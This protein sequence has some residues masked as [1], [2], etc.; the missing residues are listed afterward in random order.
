MVKNCKDIKFNVDLRHRKAIIYG[1]NLIGTTHGDGAKTHDLPLLLAHEFKAE[2]AKTKFRYIYTN[3]IHHK[4][5]KDY[6]GVTIESSRSLSAADRWHADNGYQHA[7]RALEVY[8]HCK[9]NG[10]IARFTKNI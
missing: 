5:S 8:I 3:H 10:Q 9:E 6:I 1:Q 4:Q 7:K 2:W